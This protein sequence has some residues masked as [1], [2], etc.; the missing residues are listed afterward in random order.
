M[1]LLN[2]KIL[3]PVFLTAALLS[4][5]AI[6]GQDKGS[7][8]MQGKAPM[9][10]KIFKRLGLTD[11]QKTE[12]KA[13]FK[14]SRVQG[15]SIREDR[16]AFHQEMK[17]LVK[18]GNYSEAEAKALVAQYQDSLNQSLIH[19]A[20]IKA[21]IRAVLTADQQEKLD[22]F[23]QRKGKKGKGDGKRDHHRKDRPAAE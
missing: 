18:S 4:A 9:H 8:R 12:I 23:E 17:A 3:A 13:I 14:D 20:S 15:K 16:K 21:K 7:D 2:A 5:P 10:F 6:S 11:E 22:K 19:A 1:K